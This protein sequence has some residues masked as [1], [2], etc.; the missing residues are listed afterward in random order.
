MR[1]VLPTVVA[2]AHDAMKPRHERAPRLI[3]SGVC[4]F[5]RYISVSCL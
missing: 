4:I 3:F 1:L 5:Q 2:P